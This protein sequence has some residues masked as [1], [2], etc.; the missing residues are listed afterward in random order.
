MSV[1]QSVLKVLIDNYPIVP[2]HKVHRASK[3]HPFSGGQRLRELR[4]EYKLKYEY[5]A[6][7]KAYKINETKG[8]LERL[9]KLIAA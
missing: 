3:D 4:K 1:K 2:I 5:L 6:S 9:L 8:K 7:E